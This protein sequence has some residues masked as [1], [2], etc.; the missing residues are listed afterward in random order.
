[1]HLPLH[2]LVC[3]VELARIELE[4]R[5]KAEQRE[6]IRWSLHWVSDLQVMKSNAAAGL[7]HLRTAAP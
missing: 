7:D 4:A 2:A 5:L 1:M 6:V 3:R